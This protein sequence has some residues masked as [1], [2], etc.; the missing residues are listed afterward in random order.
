MTME[1]GTVDYYIDRLS[2]PTPPL[3]IDIC[4]SNL[5]DYDALRLAD[6]LASG[7]NGGEECSG[8]TLKK[9]RLRGSQMTTW[10]F[11]ALAEAIGGG[12][13][14]TSALEELD[15]G[16]TF[17]IA[18]DV[19]DFAFGL[20]LLLSAATN[21]KHLDLEGC[22][23][24]RKAG[25]AVGDIVSVNGVVLETLNLR[26]NALEDDST[27]RLASKLEGYKSLKRIDLG[28]N[29]VGLRGAIALAEFVATNPPLLH[30]I[31]IGNSIGD[32]GAMQFAKALKSNT[33][34]VE[35]NLGYN[36]ISSVGLETLFYAIFD[37][38][39]LN[40]LADSNHTLCYLFQQQCVEELLRRG[41][42]VHTLF[43]IGNI[44]QLNEMNS[45][46]KTSSHHLPDWTR[47]L[48]LSSLSIEHLKIVI[49]L[50]KCFD[51][52]HF[53]S[54]DRTMI[55]QVLEFIAS[56]MGHEKVF[57]LVG[58]WNMP[59]LFTQTLQAC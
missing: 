2:S 55:P 56:N 50:S 44:L 33:T 41:C 15:F 46:L 25:I 31:L 16:Y 30:L 10:G 14:A 19:D 59:Q 39:S 4:D 38:S 37:T 22:S 6:A 8:T 51:M 5:T 49:Y 17:D 47:E 32:S 53:I 28:F 20:H 24:A 36:H 34:M 18:K 1:W 27:I 21:L 35:L 42:D 52:K 40:A 11:L 26:N 58:R 23:I 48:P 57:Q 13:G 7:P 54:M 43:D 29:F 45:L 12:A 3:H 9:L